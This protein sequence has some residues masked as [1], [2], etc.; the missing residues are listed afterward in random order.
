MFCPL[1][2]HPRGS[3]V[4]LYLPFLSSDCRHFQKRGRS[5]F[6]KQ[7]DTHTGPSFVQSQF[8]WVNARKLLNEVEGN[9]VVVVPKMLCF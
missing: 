3:F 4:M 2:G 8:G 7:H 6:P 9:I 1:E 5:P